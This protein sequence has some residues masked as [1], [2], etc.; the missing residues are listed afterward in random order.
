MIYVLLLSL[1]FSPLTALFSQD[2]DSNQTCYIFSY[3]KDNGDDGLHLAFSY[4]GFHW[5]ALNGDSSFLRP[6]VGSEK[7]MRDPS[8]IRGKDG[9]YHMVWTTGWLDKGIGYASSPDLLQWS[10]QKYLPVM[11]HEKDAQNCWAPEILYDE[12]HDNY[13]IFWS[14]GIPG[15]FPETDNQSDKGPPAPG[16]NHRVYCT[17]TK[18]FSSF[19]ASRIFY[20][21]GFNV[22]DPVII[23][24]EHLYYMF[25]KDETNKPF[26]PQKNIRI[27]TST[28]A[29]GPYST[30]S[31]PITGADWVEGPTVLK[32]GGKWMVYFDK[33]KLRKYGAV[34]SNDLK[35]WVD[36]SD[37]LLY[38]DGMRHGTVLE[39]PKQILNRLLEQ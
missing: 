16:R 36:V 28:Q 39:V 23:K 9:L 32:R 19:T 25:L 20:N 26:T 21:H 5:T 11:A 6:L 38:P 12:I 34:M 13:I 3:F 1:L 14:T 15:R 33:Y 18:D 27:A 2:A 24:H 35:H 37:A 30:P 31:E 10:E 17:T 29:A 7:I 8:I 4:N 22:I